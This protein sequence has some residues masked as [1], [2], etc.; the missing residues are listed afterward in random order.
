MDY[1]I[2]SNVLMYLANPASP[3]YAVCL[4]A[5]TKLADPPNRLFIFPQNL[6]EFWVSATRP[7]AANGLGLSVPQ[8]KH[9]IQRIKGLFT[10]VDENRE[11]FREWERLVQMHSIIGKNV[12]DARIVAQML[13]HG[14]DNILTFNTKDFKRFSNIT[15]IDPSSI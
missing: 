14:I 1:L 12:H 4:S 15:A 11:I 10:L 2:D 6:I 3:F 7:I 8:V 9:E 13:V 5:A